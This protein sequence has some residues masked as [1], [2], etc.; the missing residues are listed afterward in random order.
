M[1]VSDTC[2][3]NASS[4]AIDYEATVTA[5]NVIIMSTTDTPTDSWQ[6]TDSSQILQRSDNL[7]CRI[8]SPFRV[9]M[10]GVYKAVP[11]VKREE[12]MD[13]VSQ[14]ATTLCLIALIILTNNYH[15]A[16]MFCMGIQ[17]LTQNCDT[18]TN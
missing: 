2:D 8:F 10:R 14:I 13:S 18:S 11:K 17:L 16:K 9:K 4:S 15:A 3:N 12:F 1:N 7:I 5:T 6:Q